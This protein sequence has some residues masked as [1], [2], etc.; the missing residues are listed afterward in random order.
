MKQCIHTVSNEVKTRKEPHF[1]VRGYGGLI[2][3]GRKVSEMTIL[4]ESTGVNDLTRI[5]DPMP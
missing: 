2:L 5:L 4:S 1:V 3:K